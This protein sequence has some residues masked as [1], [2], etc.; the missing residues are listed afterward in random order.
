MNL[1]NQIPQRL[2]IQKPWLK[3]WFESK[4]LFDKFFPKHVDNFQ[5]CQPFCPEECESTTYTVSLS[6]TEF[7]SHSFADFLLRK[8][9]LVEKLN[10]SENFIK[11]ITH[12]F[13]II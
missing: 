10:K 2:K 13:I 12:L 9:E 7:P 3:S 8:K 5:T 6:F 11:S 1:E 4:P